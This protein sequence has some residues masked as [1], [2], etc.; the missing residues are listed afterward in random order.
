MFVSV[1]EGDGMGWGWREE[2]AGKG[3]GGGAECVRA[4]LNAYNTSKN[5]NK[6]NTI[7]LTGTQQVGGS[8]IKL[9]PTTQTSQ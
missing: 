1:G 8:P 6:K 5:R 7:F 3:G 9:T 4:C 2:G